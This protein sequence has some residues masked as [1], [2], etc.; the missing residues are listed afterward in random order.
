MLEIAVRAGNH[1]VFE[2]FRSE[3]QSVL[4][5][6]AANLCSFFALAVE[7]GMASFV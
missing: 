7:G 3:L 2:V 1:E 5:G 4:A 6:S